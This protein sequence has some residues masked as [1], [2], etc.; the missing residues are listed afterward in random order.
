MADGTVPPPP[1]PPLPDQGRKEDIATSLSEVI[2]TLREVRKTWKPEEID[3]FRCSTLGALKGYWEQIWD[4]SL[5]VPLNKD[6]GFTKPSPS[7]L[8]EKFLL[9][10]FES[11]DARGIIPEN[12]LEK[13]VLCIAVVSYC[14]R[15]A[16]ELEYMTDPR[17]IENKIKYIYNI[18]GSDNGDVGELINSLS[19]LSILLAEKYQEEYQEELPE[20]LHRPYE[21]CAQVLNPMV[22]TMGPHMEGGT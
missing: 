22:K 17:T 7:S 12:F 16:G 8:W 1:L 5:V 18:L 4:E 15:V 21:A 9:A 3:H 19:E 14:T 11:P 2:E 20:S 10:A 6:G 13:E